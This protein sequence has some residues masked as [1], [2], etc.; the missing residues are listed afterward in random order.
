MPDT[1]EAN[2][3]RDHTVWRCNRTSGSLSKPN[4]NKK[5][6]KK[7]NTQASKS[8]ADPFPHHSLLLLT[9]SVRLSHTW[10]ASSVALNRACSVL[11]PG[12]ICRAARKINQ[13]H[14]HY[15]RKSCGWLCFIIACLFFFFS[16]FFSEG[17]Y[18]FSHRPFRQLYFI[19]VGVQGNLT[20]QR[21]SSVS[22]LQAPHGAQ[23]LGSAPPVDPLQRA[24]G[25]IDFASLPLAIF[26]SAVLKALWKVP[27]P[28]ASI[29]A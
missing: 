18:A 9:A 19:F 10:P 23:A 14:I 25:C 27:E 20:P 28:A 17:H 11:R 26:C 16:V 22:F 7:K 4:K 13:L 5:K 3:E 1:I 8:F 21:R 12:K 6:E 2:T 15:T 29:T 24:S